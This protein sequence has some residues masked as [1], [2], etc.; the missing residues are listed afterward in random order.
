MKKI[1]LSILLICT[2][3][4]PGCIVSFLSKIPDHEFETFE[5]HRTGN[6]TNTHIV[7]GPAKREEGK[8]VI[9]SVKV[10]SDWGPVYSLNVT[11][12]G[13]KRGVAEP[14]TAVVE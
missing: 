9:D 8:M 3:L 14:V 7:A 13:Y 11:L 1:I 2:L 10:T 6:F 5:Y 4:F 12:T